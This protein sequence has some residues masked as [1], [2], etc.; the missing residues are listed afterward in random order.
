MLE[1]TE[2]IQKILNN[3]WWDNAYYEV[4]LPTESCRIR[5]K[6]STNN[7]N[8]CYGKYIKI[9]QSIYY[10]L[11][12]LWIKKIDLRSVNMDKIFSMVSY[13]LVISWGEHWME[14]RKK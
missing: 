1:R 14:L 3:A 7:F 13:L 2:A 11:N 9:K 4:T 6:V 8:R 12:I 5:G 10:A